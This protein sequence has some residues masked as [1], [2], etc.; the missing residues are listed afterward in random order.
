M[1]DN[2]TEIEQLIYTGGG[3][4]KGQPDSGDF[5][6]WAASKGIDNEMII[7]ELH[8]IGQRIQ[9]GDEA[10]YSEFKSTQ[11]RLKQG[12]KPGLFGKYKDKDYETYEF[13]VRNK[14][15][16]LEESE[17]GSLTEL[18][19]Y[20]DFRETPEKAPY[21]V[22]ASYLQDGRLAIVRVSGIGKI[23]TERN[24]RSGNYF[25]HIYVFPKGV[26]LEDVDISKL[27]FKK[28]LERKFWGTDAEVA[29]ETLSATTVE[30]M[31]ASLNPDNQ[32]IELTIDYINLSNEIKKLEENDE[33]EKADK[34]IE[35]SKKLKAEIKNI[36][37]KLDPYMLAE[38]IGKFK[39]ETKNSIIEEAEKKGKKNVSLGAWKQDIRIKAADKIERATLSTIEQ[40]SSFEQRF[41]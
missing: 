34:L 39:N 29:P 32:L 10:E 4:H 28:G 2:K 18:S 12:A 1:F 8:R 40:N 13:I 26:K 5:A 27:V 3:L 41:N 15:E 6:K 30:E 11:R 35:K 38:R 21:R 24:P 22:G 25:E 14:T 7:S 37:D 9:K 17:K 23:Y 19:R 31:Q 20:E 36:F 33:Y 16:I